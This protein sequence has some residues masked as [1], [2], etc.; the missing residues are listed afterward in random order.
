MSISK[1]DLLA[2]L[3]PK[4]E[5]I[6]IEGIGAIKLRQLTVAESDA[7]RASL[8]KEDKSSEFGLR[9]LGTSLVDDEGNRMFGDDEIADLRNSSGTHVDKLIESVLVLNGFKKAAEAK[10]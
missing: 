2:A 10:N 6:E 7:L 4:I 3:Q 5:S 8:D 9:M 1:T